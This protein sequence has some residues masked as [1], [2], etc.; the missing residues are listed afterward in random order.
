[1][2]SEKEMPINCNQST[3]S[4]PFSWTTNNLPL[5]SFA[6]AKN[7]DKA[8]TSFSAVGGW[9][10]KTTIPENS[11]GGNKEVL[12]KSESL[13][14]STA[15]SSFANS[16]NLPLLMPLGAYLAGNPFDSRNPLTSVRTFSSS[17]NL[18]KS[19]I[20]LPPDGFRS[21]FQSFLNH[22]LGDA[23]I[24]FQDFFNT[25]SSSYKLNDIANQNSSASKCG[26]AMA[27]FGVSNDMSAN[28][29]SHSNSDNKEIF[30]DFSRGGKK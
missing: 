30:K 12:R 28:S 21:I 2:I 20:T 11:F 8:L 26:L 6:S 9:I 1:M 13:L 7:D 5:N 19:D 4:N 24:T 23:G 15:F 29:Y 14:K 10:T 16:D 18:G 3:T 25:F 27:Y 17:R 22:L